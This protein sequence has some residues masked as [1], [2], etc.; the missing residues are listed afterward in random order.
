MSINDLFL[1]CIRAFVLIALLAI[2]FLRGNYTSLAKHPGWKQILVGFCLITAATLLDITDEIPGLEKFIFIGDT[3]YEAFLEKLPGYLLGFVLVLIG[4][5]KMIPSLQ[6]AEQNEE[7]LNESEKRFRQ[8]F[9][10]NPEPVILCKLKS[11]K[12]TD[13]NPAL[14]DLI[15]EDR[16]KII[17]ENLLDLRI[18]R[19]KAI[20]ER[21][22]SYLKEHLTAQNFEVELLVSD[23]LVKEY[24]LS[25]RTMKV[26]DLDDIA[27]IALS[28]ISKVKEA[29]RALIKIDHLRKD[30]I[31][32]AAHELKT[33]LSVLIGYCEALVDP[34]ISQE[35]SNE[36]RHYFLQQIEKKGFM[37]SS[38]I[39]DLLDIS[40][41]D[42]GLPFELQ[43]EEVNPNRLLEEV[44]QDFR[45]QAK[46][47]TIHL[48]FNPGA[49]CLLTC[50][51]FR[52]IQV[53]ENLFSNAVKYTKKGGTIVLSGCDYLDC[54]VF[55][56]S[57]NGRGMTSEQVER[58]Y[59]RF[60]RVDSSNTAQSGLGLGMS[61][62]KQIIEAHNG[63]I[64]INSKPGEGTTVK[65]SLPKES[66]Q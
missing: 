58:I 34:K 32:T 50:D 28:D 43:M 41:I 24:F 62:V 40:K 27:L 29:E 35:M 38:L 45:L 20:V 39:D 52:I 3:I 10:S 31:S 23:G 17:N 26:I 60:Y 61:I 14:E 63:T 48:E 44:F 7:A 65:I 54:Y 37:L 9:E 49:H 18:W 42:A 22:Y 15:Q 53:L 25:A 13:V 1:E 64:M 33:P 59:E 56:V 19:N 51:R 57:D 6:K 21:F 66:Q 11:G 5:F 36:Q 30:F 47:Q 46:D 4:F 12:V 8:I 2:L 55:S 16:D